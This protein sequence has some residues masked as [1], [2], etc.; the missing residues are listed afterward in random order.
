MNILTPEQYEQW[1]RGELCIE[2]QLDEPPQ[3]NPED[4]ERWVRER[5]IKPNLKQ[6]DTGMK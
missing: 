5:K 6:I 3:V 2:F 4:F 1:K